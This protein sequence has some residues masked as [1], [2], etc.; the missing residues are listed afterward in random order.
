MTVTVMILQ[1]FTGVI[2]TYY[3]VYTYEQCVIYYSQ[4]LYIECLLKQNLNFPG[5]LCLF[6]AT[7]FI[8]FGFFYTSSDW[9]KDCLLDVCLPTKYKEFYTFTIW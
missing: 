5:K 8:P 4:T 1:N 3:S 7:E 9:Y 6:P 2:I